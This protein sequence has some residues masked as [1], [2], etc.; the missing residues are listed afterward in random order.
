M[1]QTM[2]FTIIAKPQIQEEYCD[3]F[4]TVMTVDVRRGD[5]VVGS[6]VWIVAGVPDYQRGSA[7][8]AGHQAGFEAVRV[9]GDSPDYWC[10]ES[11]RGEDADYHAISSAII[12]AVES[13]ALA[14]HR[15]RRD[16]AAD[17]ELR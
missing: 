10:P 11:F 16:V 7:R 6:D 17:P 3:E 13:A 5:G 12:E 2:N 14:A 1:T 8:A 15:E 4:E 9:F